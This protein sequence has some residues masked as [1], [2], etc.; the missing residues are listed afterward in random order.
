MKLEFE[1]LGICVKDIKN[2]VEFYRDVM[3]FEIQWDGGCFA[4]ARMSKSGVFFNLFAGP[5]NDDIIFA[6]G[7][8]PTFQFSC[9]VDHPEDVDREYERLLHAGATSIYPPRDED[10]GM[11][12]CFVADPEGN[13][14]EICCPLDD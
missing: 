9:G 5:K 6:T 13:Q 3:G 14:I 4:G 7:I 11:R 12:I 1:A 2:M 10:Y 8:N